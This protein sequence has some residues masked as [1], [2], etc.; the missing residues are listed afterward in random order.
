MMHKPV[1]AG[2]IATVLATI[3]A[4][5]AAALLPFSGTATATAAPFPDASCDPRPFRGIIA[6]SDSAGTSNFGAFTYGHNVCIIGA[7]GPVSG[8]FAL[9]FGTSSFSGLLDGMAVPRDGVPGL[10]DQLFTYTV[11]AGTGL[12]AGATGSLTNTGTVDVRGG[13]PSR[14][15]LDLAGTIDAPAIPEPASWMT[16]ILGLGLVGGAARRRTAHRQ[17]C[18]APNLAGR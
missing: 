1:F 9:D 4:P 16:M 18:T 15:W 8:V 2:A 17:G 3:A 10:F 7:A 12:F 14:L 13:P 6:P 5:A 11:T